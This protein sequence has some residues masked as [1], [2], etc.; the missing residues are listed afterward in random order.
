VLDASRSV[1]VTGN[2]VYQTLR[3]EFVKKK[4]Q[5]YL[6]LRDQHQ[7][8]SRK[9]TYLQL[10]KARAN[11][12]QLDWKE[13][14]IKKPNNIG[15]QVFDDYDLAEVRN[16]IDWGPFFIAWQMKGRFPAV[17]EDEKYGEEARKLFDDANQLLDTIIGQNLL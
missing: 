8:R 12:M 3:D 1:S 10:E 5:E 4:Q 17:L 13:D 9:K 7:N 16:Y 11:A 14:K 15:I 2:L 6:E